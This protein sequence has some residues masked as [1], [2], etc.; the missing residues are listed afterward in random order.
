[1]KLKVDCCEVKIKRIEFSSKL[2]HI[3]NKYGMKG[4]CQ[5]Y[6]HRPIVI[7]RKRIIGGLIG[8]GSDD[9]VIEFE[10]KRDADVVWSCYRARMKEFA[11]II[12]ERFIKY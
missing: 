7:N 9:L 12:I 3:L 6:F 2:I 1:M 11:E 10:T 5:L 4:L 8:L